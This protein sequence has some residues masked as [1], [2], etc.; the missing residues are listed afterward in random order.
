MREVVPYFNAMVRELL[1][2][3]S[4]NRGVLIERLLR[5]SYVW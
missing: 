2:N 1:E 3:C 4:L 5:V